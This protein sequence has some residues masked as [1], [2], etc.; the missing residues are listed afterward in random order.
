M[1]EI[2][3]GLLLA[4]LINPDCIDEKQISSFVSWI[5]N[6]DCY[7]D[8]VEN[9]NDVRKSSSI[10]AKCL[11]CEYE[12]INLDKVSSIEEAM[13]AYYKILYLVQLSTP[14]FYLNP[15]LAINKKEKK[16]RIGEILV[17]FNNKYIPIDELSLDSSFSF[18]EKSEFIKE[19]VL[20]WKDDVY[21]R[22]IKTIRKLKENPRN[23]PKKRIFSI[24][25]II[26]GV[27][28]ISLIAMFVVTLYTNNQFLNSLYLPK[29]FSKYTF[30]HFILLFSMCF[31]GLGLLI[32]IVEMIYCAIT[33]S[34]YRKI[35]NL[36]F[37]KEDQLLKI[38]QKQGDKLQNY[39]IKNV[40]KHNKLDLI[41]DDF[42][43]C[44]KIYEYLL[45]LYHINYHCKKIKKD[46]IWLISKIVLSLTLVFV[47][48]LAIYFV[49]AYFGGVK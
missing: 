11:Y 39:L 22:L 27:F 25:H 3:K 26:L 23:L 19:K 15:L 16:I 21:N 30:K 1:R 35:R 6:Q 33:I 9:I 34:K 31:A 5:K 36:V 7:H 43:S 41:V 40:E 18:Q 8:L 46:R 47:I 45:Y 10:L 12:M 14:A 37:D 24:G 17:K 28:Y 20:S 13:I 32:Y 38:I 4:E 44:L 48:L 42:S 2:E 29:S 49:Y